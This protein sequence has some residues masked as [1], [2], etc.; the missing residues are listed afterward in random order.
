MC[1]PPPPRSSAGR[2][3]AA[4]AG[5]SSAGSVSRS[6]AA[7]RQ[8]RRPRRR[9]PP[10]GPEPP[11]GHCGTSNGRGRGRTARRRPDCPCDC[12][13]T[14][15]RSKSSTASFLRNSIM[16]RTASRADLVDHL[17]QRDEIAG[18]LRH[19]HRLAVAQQLHQL[20]DL[21]VERRLARGDR[22]DRRLHALDV[23][24]VIGAPDVDQV[25][26]AAVELVL[27][28][29]DVGG[30]IG[31]AAVRLDQ[32][33]ID[34]VAEGGGAEQRLLAVF[35]VL[36]RRALRRRQAALIDV[37]LGAQEVDG[38]GDLVVAGLRSASA[39]RRT[40]RA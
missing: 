38:L 6:T 25:A 15:A 14:L 2:A 33:P 36:D 5:S 31:V 19:L 20:H 10:A 28:I 1:Q 7:S 23:A 29:G 24:A 37:A 13:I 40:R 32:R 27:V 30:E 4:G 3:P 8:E 17:A 12:S 18:A 34:I 9:S 16:K 21:D 26:K 11:R 35:P 39:R 22:L